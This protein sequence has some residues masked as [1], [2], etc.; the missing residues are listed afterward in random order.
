MKL[1]I[2]DVDILER[3]AVLGVTQADFGIGADKAAIGT[4]LGVVAQE[5]KIGSGFVLA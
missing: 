2:G 1:A 3:K 5:N 4:D